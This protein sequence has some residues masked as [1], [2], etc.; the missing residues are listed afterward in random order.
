M[1]EGAALAL[2]SGGSVTG[3]NQSMTIGR[4]GALDLGDAG[5][6]LR[7]AGLGG[8]QA[9]QE[10][11]VRDLKKGAPKG[12]FSIHAALI[13]RAALSASWELSASRV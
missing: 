4:A 5:P 1:T 3:F 6:G 10:R 9:G 13:L 7:R 8:P 2:R 12:P 11:P